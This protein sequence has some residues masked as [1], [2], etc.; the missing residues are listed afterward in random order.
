MEN[1]E[2]KV[3]QPGTQIATFDKT[4]AD[5]VLNRVQELEK[6]G[7][8]TFPKNYSVENALQSAYLILQ[9]TEDKEG[10]PALEVC[11]KVSVANALFD[12]VVQ[13][14]NP[15]KK[16]CYFIVRGNKLCLDRS[17]FGE[18][19]VLKRVIPGIK[20]EDV[21]ANV[22][23]VG[24]VVEIIQD[25]ETLRFRLVKHETKFENRDN[26][27]AGVYSVI[28]KDGIPYVEFMTQKEIQ[29]SWSHR[30]NKGTVQ[31][32]FPQEMAKRTVLK[33]GSKIFINASD[34]SNLD[35]AESYNRTLKD[36]YDNDTV[37][38]TVEREAAEKTASELPPSQPDVK[39][40]PIQESKPAPG[41][42]QQTIPTAG[43]EPAGQSQNQKRGPNY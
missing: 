27:I 3:E 12:M 31:Q 37:V 30:S 7:R 38:E 15:Q 5:T 29:M 6:A 24:D 4:I 28:L 2:K 36:E 41:Q 9:T 43:S 8:I 11:T 23:Y 20:D 10:R 32:E 18:V 26:G 17:Y 40:E 39:P 13:G 21:F 14:L 16:Q 35:I 22:I 1:T 42:V 19:A 34:D 33:R 25:P